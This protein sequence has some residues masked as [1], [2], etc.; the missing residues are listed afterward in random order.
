M[1]GI[2]ALCVRVR[3]GGFDVGTESLG[4]LTRPYPAPLR[5][6]LLRAPALTLE[7]TTRLNGEIGECFAAATADVAKMAGIELADIDFVG[8][9]GQ[10][11]CHL[12]RRGQGDVPATLQL[13]DLDII[14]ERTGAVVVGDFRT[15]DVAAG[16][17]G[18]PLMPF[19]DWLL[20]RGRP[21]TVC[22]NLGGISAL[23]LVTKE[24]EGCRA[25]DAGPCNIPLDLLASRLT[26]G[27][28]AFDPGGR[29]AATG[30]IESILMDRLERH[31][32][33][34]RPPPKSSGREEFGAAFVE[35]LLGRHQHLALRD[36]LA[37]L[38][39]FAARAVGHAIDHH[40]SIE[41]GARE[42][43]ISGGGVHNLT[44]VRHLK[45]ELFPV[46]VTESSEHGI[47]PD[48]KEALLFAV[49]AN[50]R[51][52]GGAGNLPGVTGA[53]WPVGLGKVT[54]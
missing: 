2:D 52:L 41:G 20:F 14:A 49:L 10:T 12:P 45:K 32:F 48:A 5:E 50:E 9:H 34:L 7:E 23:T 54:W 47:D 42:V 43:V 25:F 24:I 30:R 35:D 13:G 1:D 22:V 38:C 44:L 27:D 16:G 26:N 46:P 19:L 51:I 36:I 15:R 3:G 21:R 18:A 53:R 37:T 11:V 6:I 39:A 8:S 17:E 31:P 28:E 29:F 4:F 40:L 33:L